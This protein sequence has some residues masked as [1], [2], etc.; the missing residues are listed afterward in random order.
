MPVCPLPEARRVLAVSV[1]LAG[2]LLGESDT[3]DLRPVDVSRVALDPAT[4]APV[5]ILRESDG[6][7]R[8]L[9][10]WIG[11][12]EA[13]SIALGLE[14]V[15]VPRP[16]PHDLMHDMIEELGGE[17]QRVI[18]T[19]L[20]DSIYY[21]V[22]ELLVDGRKIEVDARPSDAIAVALRFSAPIFVDERVLVQ[23][24]KHDEENPRKDV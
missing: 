16:N 10:I 22:M 8:E 2:C 6:L 9:P 19:E 15:E 14:G 17:L 23:G 13:R 21:A 20:R 18:V 4:R 5:V 11:V 12:Y 3:R 24:S 7:Q 1:L